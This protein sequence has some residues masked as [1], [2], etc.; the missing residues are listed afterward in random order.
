MKQ[1]SDDDFDEAQQ[2]TVQAVD[3]RAGGVSGDRSSRPA[4]CCAPY[5]FGSSNSGYEWHG[6]RIEFGVAE[7]TDDFKDVL[8]LELVEG[9]W[10]SR[11]DDGQTY[12]AVVINQ[13][14]REDLFGDGP[15]LGQNIANDRSPDELVGRDAEKRVVGVIAAYREDGEFD[16]ERNYVL[17]R[18]TMAR[19]RDDRA[20][21][22]RP[23]AAEPADQGARREPP[24]RSRS[25]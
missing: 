19:H 24:P 22:S 2:E 10:F 17:Y 9:R 11:E 12:D 5:Q 13:D 1:T 4:R 14:M 6:R 16:G 15:A 8:G 3:A 7:V 23:P 25:A 18:K 21:A 20:A